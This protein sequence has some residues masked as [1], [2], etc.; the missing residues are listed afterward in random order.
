MI[1]ETELLKLKL[2]Q[3]F[4]L[5]LIIGTFIV[6]VGIIAPH[7]VAEKWH[8][9]CSLVSHLGVAFLTVALLG[10]FFEP[11][12]LD[13]AMLKVRSKIEDQTQ[14]IEK[15]TNTLVDASNEQKRIMGETAEKLEIAK[16]AAEAGIKAL[17]ISRRK[18]YE[19]AKTKLHIDKLIE[20]ATN[21]K[22]PVKVDLLGICLRDFF[23]S[24]EP[25]A[26]DTKIFLD[27][28]KEIS[29]KG[30][31]AQQEVQI[32]VL[33]LYPYTIAAL[34]RMKAE[35]SQDGPYVRITSAGSF[36]LRD[37]IPLLPRTTFFADFRSSMRTLFR[38]RKEISQILQ[39][40]Y[41]LT[42]PMLHLWRFNNEIFIEPYHLGKSERKHPA[43]R[44]MGGI[45][46]M[47]QIIKNENSS[48]EDF[49]NHFLYLW[50][51]SE[52]NDIERVVDEEGLEFLQPDNLPDDLREKIAEFWP[53]R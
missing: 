6:A 33:V 4:W 8:A 18:A 25:L 19:I 16:V 7:F 22:E 29:G 47:M 48:F 3:T 43:L 42:N 41:C 53:T 30:S 34:N 28:L 24:G 31:Q 50:K 20:E 15:Q 51:T 32:R 52:G 35:E 14:K 11:L 23:K 2:R 37:L 27:S 36:R 5:C 26:G 39:V 10:K 40:R 45:V 13:Q 21:L 49:K 12:L 9:L 38:M 1:E 17:Y 44:C 46:P